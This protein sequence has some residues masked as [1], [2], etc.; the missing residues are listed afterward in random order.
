[1]PNTSRQSRRCKAKEEKRVNYRNRVDKQSSRKWTTKPKDTTYRVKT[2][3]SENVAAIS[4]GHGNTY[5]YCKPP[6]PLTPPTAEEIE[7]D[8]CWWQH[9]WWQDSVNYESARKTPWI[10]V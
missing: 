2:T 7:E 8:R 1:M 9:V 3:D 5:I 10:V 6:P 4:S